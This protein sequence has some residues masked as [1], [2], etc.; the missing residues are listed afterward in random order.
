MIYALLDL[1]DRVTPDHLRAALA[2]WQYCEQSARYIFGDRT[3]DA[4]ADRIRDALRANGEMTETDL[5][6]LFGRHVKAGR[7]SHA[8]TTLQTA[9]LIDCEER[10]TGGRPARYWRARS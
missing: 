10:S 6:A 7:L 8:L 2:F 1:S 4:V 3:G 9:G 5:H